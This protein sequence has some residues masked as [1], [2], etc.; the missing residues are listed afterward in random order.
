MMVKKIFIYLVSLI[1]SSTIV[2]T[3][4]I[5]NNVDVFISSFQFNYMFIIPTIIFSIIIYI[6]IKYL[7]KL[8]SKPEI[9]PSSK[10]WKEQIVFNYAFI[11]IFLTSL[12]FLL[13]FYPGTCMVDT[14]QLL[15]D[16]TGYSFQYPLIYSL[17]FSKLYYLFY[18]LFHSMNVAF[19]L[20]SLIQLIFMTIVL[21]YLITWAH[22]TFKSNIFTLLTILYFNIFTIFSNLNSAH[23]RDSLFAAFILLL[24]PLLYEIIDTKGECLRKDK[25]KLR[26]AIIMGF[27]TLIRNNG[28]FMILVLL[29]VLFIKYKKRIKDLILITL[30]VLFICS[31]PLLLPKTYRTEP[32]F[33]ESVS[34]PLE[35]I[36]YV[37]KYESLSNSDKDYIDNIMPIEVM[38]DNYNPFSV[39]SI[40]W[41]IMFDRFYLNN[42]KNKFMSVWT[43]NMVNH[44]NGYIKAYLLCT[45]D[46]WS[47]HQFSDYE[48]RFLEIEFNDTNVESYY[49]DLKNETILPSNISNFLKSFYEKTTIYFNNGTLFWIYVFFCLLIYYKGNNKYLLLFVPFLGIWLNL[50]IGTPLSSAF[51]YMCAFGYALPF[52]IPLCF[53][54]SVD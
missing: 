13:T 14:L 26:C 7:L 25:F 29:L 32:L 5:D 30:S 11:S 31:I 1:F 51:R 49:R 22:K 36:A 45:Y 4:Y 37:A 20:I 8:L 43:R 35:Q 33:Q 54:R 44:F 39:D 34:I 46:L 10:I 2:L 19:F 38:V 50:M 6:I 41:D 23:L 9:K 47:V 12:L 28:I 48:S 18:Y 21:S 24:I 52:I 15:I 16:P 27:L 17:F 3:L 42:T 40:K 53:F